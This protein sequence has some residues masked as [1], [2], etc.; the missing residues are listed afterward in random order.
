MCFFFKSRVYD[1][2]LLYLQHT[3]CCLLKLEFISDC[4]SVWIFTAE[5]GGGTSQVA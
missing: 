4:I 2:S 3:I 5:S 1:I